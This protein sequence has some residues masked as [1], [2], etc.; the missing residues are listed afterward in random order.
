[1]TK[2]PPW[3]VAHSIT[4]GH[5]TDRVIQLLQFLAVGH[6]YVC[7]GLVVCHVSMLI[8]MYVEGRNVRKFSACME[9]YVILLFNVLL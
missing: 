8:C 6:G 3:Y 1:M 5:P 2:V 9:S 7:H 4:N